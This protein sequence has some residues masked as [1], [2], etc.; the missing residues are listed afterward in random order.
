MNKTNLYANFIIICGLI[1]IAII[2]TNAYKYKFT[3]NQ[4]INVT[5]NAIKDFSADLVKWQASFSRN[6]YDLKTASNEL[7]NDQEI[8]KNF[9][10]SQGIKPNEIIFEAVN[11][12]K[13]IRYTTDT[14]GNSY[15][16]FNGYILNQDVTIESKDLNKVEK[17]SREISNLIS[18]GIELNSSSPN[19]YY[20]KLEDLKLQLIAQASE[21]AKLRA[22]NIATKS[23]CKLGKLI[24]ADLGIFQI[25][26]KNDNEE[27]SYGGV[28]NTT[29]KEKTANITIKASYT[30]N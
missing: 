28:F 15:T 29:S 27:Y 4:N 7:K 2:G 20:S 23:N 24:K 26:G 17:A 5:G 6:N 3:T 10:I 12:T 11:I 25:T 21:N 19:Y 13:D 14:N 18:N 16:Q 8:V 22:E 1:I 30:I 9:L